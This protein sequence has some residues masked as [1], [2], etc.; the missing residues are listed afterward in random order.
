MTSNS[1]SEYTR[2]R[3]KLQTLQAANVPNQRDIERVIDELEQLQ[4][5]IKVEH[6]NKGKSGLAG[7][8][9]ID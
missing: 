8:N 1:I 5:K 4:L 3:A 7:N 2:L 9:P 6:G